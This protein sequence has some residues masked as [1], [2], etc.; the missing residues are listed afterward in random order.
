M[1]LGLTAA[2]SLAADAPAHA[3][4]PPTAAPITLPFEKLTLPN[5]LVV[6][7]A[8]D[9]RAPVVAMELRFR[10]GARHDPAGRRG[11]SALL[12]EVYAR[13][14]SRR[15]REGDRD[16]LFHALGL[17]P[18]KVETF[19]NLD[20]TWV[21]A[22]TPAQALPLLLWLE[23]DRLAFASEGVDEGVVRAA[24]AAVA[25]SRAKPGFVETMLH[26]AFGAVY[27]AAHP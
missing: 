26:E 9:H 24:R 3:A 22:S 16:A 12:G 13:G 4:P 1:A 25:Q 2:A 14:P 10:V 20:C 8:E 19:S 18:W 5:G 6:I 21:Q 17:E 15:V 7:L 23:A 11:L 27:G